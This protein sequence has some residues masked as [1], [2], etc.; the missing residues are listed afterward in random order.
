MMHVPR[1]TLSAVRLVVLFIASS[2][3]SHALGA[4]PSAT[5]RDEIQHLLTN[6]ER[7]GCQFFRNGEW[8]GAAKAKDHLNQKY[9]YL[10]KKGLV[11]KSEDFIRLAA[12]ESSV[13]GKAYQVRCKGTEPMPSAVWLNEELSRY[14]EQGRAKK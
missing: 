11:R 10:L 5:V 4:E 9:N 1:F 6:L 7:S 2:L 13:S 12:T 14:R 8:Y 3:V